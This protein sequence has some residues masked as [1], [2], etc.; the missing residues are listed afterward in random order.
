MTITNFRDVGDKAD[1]RNFL[2]T[3][4]TGAS[5]LRTI[6][7]T[8][9]FYFVG[10]AGNYV[11]VF[12]ENFGFR[13]KNIDLSTNTNFVGS[14]ESLGR[15]FM[16]VQNVGLY[17][18][19]NQG[20]DWYLILDTPVAHVATNNDGIIVA[21][22]F[23]NSTVHYSVDNGE[24]FVISN[25]AQGGANI[26]TRQALSYLPANGA[27]VYLT[28]GGTINYSGSGNSWTNYNPGIFES[29]PTACVEYQGNIYYGDQTGNIYIS[30]VIGSPLTNITNK[31]YYSN[32]LGITS[33]VV[34][35]LHVFKNT[36]YLAS[37]DN[38]IEYLE[39]NGDIFLP[40]AMAGSSSAI[41][42]LQEYNNELLGVS[43]SSI[44]KTFTR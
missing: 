8:E 43:G 20:D 38:R 1:E 28:V 16:A 23:N 31:R 19:D 33:G 13:R 18:S 36:L 39:N 15:I 40:C 2:G 4:I 30:S 14:A 6:T 3:D 7:S 29:T 10:G 11:A 9:N 21:I 35:W 26:Q 27:F 41:F 44:I 22:N 25:T 37:T 5:Q 24:N 12:K 42:Q 32:D 17:A 34:S